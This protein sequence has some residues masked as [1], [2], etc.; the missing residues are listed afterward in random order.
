MKIVLS[1]NLYPMEAVINASYNF[2]EKAYIFLDENKK[3]NSIVVYFK[4]KKKPNEKA[5]KKLKNEFINEL[6]NCSLRYQIS[7]NNKK[8]R[9]YIIGRALY[10]P[11]A[12]TE[13]EN[14]EDNKELD[15]QEDPLGIAIPWEEKYGKPENKKNK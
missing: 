6:I 12:S 11:F 4:N 9:E 13:L 7:K 3:N 14:L 1:K 15:Y 5:F 2:L 8:V 10:T